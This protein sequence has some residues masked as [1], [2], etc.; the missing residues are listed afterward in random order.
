MYV[1]R[2]GIL[3]KT[4]KTDAVT[5]VRTV[6]RYFKYDNIEEVRTALKYFQYDN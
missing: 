5:N 6:W 1:Q 2:D 3:N 4:T